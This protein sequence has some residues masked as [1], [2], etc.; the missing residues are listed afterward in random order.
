MD[1]R[2][3]NFDNDK[4]TIKGLLL[5][6]VFHLEYKT[7]NRSRLRFK[8]TYNC[9]RR[10]QIECC[11]YVGIYCNFNVIW[12]DGI[13][14]IMKPHERANARYRHKSG[15]KSVIIIQYNI[16][17]YYYY[18]N[19]IKQYN[20]LLVEDCNNNLE[21]TLLGILFHQTIYTSI[22]LY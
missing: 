7:W 20:M 9:Y 2:D 17:T 13:Q 3:R 8:I 15:L 4:R 22:I 18:Y 16:G 21:R 19:K 6:I 10:S 14:T 5:W 12:S 11:L 1:C